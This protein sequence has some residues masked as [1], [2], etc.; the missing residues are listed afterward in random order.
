[1]TQDVD[2]VAHLG[3]CFDATYRGLGELAPLMSNDAFVVVTHEMSRSFGE[4]ALSMR[5]YTN[6]PLVPLPV[7]SAL[8]ARSNTLDPSGTLTLYAVAVVLGPRLLVS[9][10]DA[11]EIVSEPRA[12]EIFDEG[13]LVTVRQVRRVGELV[14]EPGIDETSWLAGVRELGDMVEFGQNAESFGLFR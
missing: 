2:V 10:R 8:L 9:L 12:R 7:I 3:D 5:E 13:Q 4:V 11:L 6:Q 1:V 14:A